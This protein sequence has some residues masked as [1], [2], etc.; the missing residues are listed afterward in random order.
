MMSCEKGKFPSCF[1]SESE[2]QLHELSA[3]KIDKCSYLYHP[4]SFERDIIFKE[5]L[6]GLTY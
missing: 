3:P 1:F 4:S 2:T 6:F 5:S